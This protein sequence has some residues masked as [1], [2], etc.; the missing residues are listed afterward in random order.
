[1][2]EQ[3]EVA[4]ADRSHLPSAGGVSRAARYAAV[5]E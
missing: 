4:D 5:D 2:T 3:Y 1:M